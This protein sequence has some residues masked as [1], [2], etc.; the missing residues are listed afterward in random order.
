MSAVLHIW[1]GRDPA[2]A[3]RIWPD[4]EIPAPGLIEEA[5]EHLFVLTGAPGA[6][7]AD[8]LIDELPLEALRS[9]EPDGA[10]WRWAPGFHAGTVECRL[11][12]PTAS[13]AFEITTD[14]AVRKLSR[15]AFDAMVREVL[16][17]TFAL[18]ALSP[19]RK[20]VARGVGRRPPPIARLEFL[21]SRMQALIQTVRA[22]DARPRRVLR[23]E[24]ALT[25]Y[26]RSG[27]ATAPEVLKSFR[28]GRLIQETGTPR[29][30]AALQGHLPEIIRSKVR[31][32]SLDIPAHRQMKASLE[33][34]A[35]WLEGVGV[36]LRA[37]VPPDPEDGRMARLWAHRTRRMARDLRGLLALSL[38]ASVGPG[39]PRPDAAPI[40]LGEPQYRRFA[41]LHRDF[42]RGVANV[43]GDFLQ[44]P[45]A[46]TFDLYEL[47]AYLRLTR[48]A[49][50]RFGADRVDVSGLFE[51][52][53]GVTLA[54]GQAVVRLPA[55]GIALC[56]QRR[57]REYWLEKDGRGSFSREMRPDVAIESLGDGDRLIVL[58]AKYRIGAGLNEALASA[59]MY[60]DA[61]VAADGDTGIRQMVSA[62]YLLSPA[63]PIVAGTW[64]DA[65]MPGRLFHPA[66]R[67]QFRFGAVS[68]AP[69]MSAAQIGLALEAILQDAETAGEETVA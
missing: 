8:L 45:L 50:A 59:H 54:A 32:S 66:Y 38:F 53:R 30:P 57:Y 26:W 55:A 20:G 7:Q 42:S 44:M 47:W 68:L 61:L 63:S 22:I 64:N 29:L 39:P 5:Q 27:R 2:R 16:E 56:F 69:G 48:A 15:D 65:P 3:V 13:Y 62:A 58:D 37:S 21:R 35:R 46:R 4:A 24:D 43:F 11:K 1:P 25:P 36:V 40:W 6:Q 14:P 12:L 17:D 67:N 31:R 10:R 41:A 9:P 51:A 52:G 49:I 18:F 33:V 28:S 19:F 23:A 60:R 34:W